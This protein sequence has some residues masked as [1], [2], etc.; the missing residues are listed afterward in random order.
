MRRL[1]FAIAG[2]LLAVSASAQFYYQDSKNVDML[3]HS[4][5]TAVQRSEII[6]PQVNGYNVY[7][8]DLHLHTIYSD[9]DVTPEYRVREAWNDG[10]D[11]VASTEHVEYRPHERNMI[12]YLKVYVRDDAGQKGIQS[13]LNHSVRLYQ[14]SAAGYGITVIPG[15]EIT[16][17]PKEIGHYNALFTTDNNTIYDA[18]PME[19]IRK[20]RAQGAIIMQNHPGWTRSD[21]SMMDFEKKV[22][23]AGL[24]DG[25][26]IMNDIEFYP[27]AI[28]RALENNFFMSSNTDAH[29]PTYEAFRLNGSFR[30]MT[31]ILAKDKSLDSLK[32]AMLAHRTLAYSYGSI[33]GEEQLLKDFFKASM[34]VEVLNVN[35]NGR[36]TIALKNMS[37][38]A[39]LLDFGGNPV[40]LDP[41]TSIRRTVG[42]DEDLKFSVANMWC[43]EDAHPEVVIEVK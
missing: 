4:R 40:V 16:R 5:Q 23:E 34:V 1:V 12:S 32:E 9:G 41:F 25:I 22:Y 20:A 30:N 35:P 17:N 43:G 14:A 36:R 26:E 24:V 11:V 10:L 31:L 8:S 42:P 2:L 33:A 6:L 15:I 19:S 28:A 3:R 37:S 27:K 38:F 21:L 13:D 18:D 39:Y 7:K 29:N